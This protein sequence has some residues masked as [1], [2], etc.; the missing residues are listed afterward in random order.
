MESKDS[1]ERILPAYIK[2]LYDTSMLVWKEKQPLWMA[3]ERTVLIQ[4]DGN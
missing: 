3:K 1:G 2:T 4:K